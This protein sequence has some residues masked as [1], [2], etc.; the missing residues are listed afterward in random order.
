MCNISEIYC[1]RVQNVHSSWQDCFDSQ[2]HVSPI[3]LTRE[4]GFYKILTR[5]VHKS[6]YA[7]SSVKESER[8]LGPKFGTRGPSSINLD[9]SLGIWIAMLR[10]DDEGESP[11][12][13][14]D[15]SHLTR[16]GRIDDFKQKKKELWWILW[17]DICDQ[18]SN[19]NSNIL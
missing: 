19:S 9:F 5:I 13:G 2:A 6:F 14:K 16:G 15:D 10:Q 18:F 1:I 7:L 12:W 4:R 17:V 8:V 3:L 11:L